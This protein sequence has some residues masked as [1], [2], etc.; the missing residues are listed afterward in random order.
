MSFARKWM[1]LEIITLSKV[2]QTEKDKYCMFSLIGQEYKI[3]SVWGRAPVGKGAKGDSEGV[4]Y[5]IY[6]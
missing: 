5:F 1:E 6:M 4:E 2:S 3:G